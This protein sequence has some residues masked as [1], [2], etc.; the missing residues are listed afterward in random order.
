MDE[1]VWDLRIR[2]LPLQ[3][4]WKESLHQALRFSG[5][6]AKYAILPGIIPRLRS[7]A[8]VMAQFLFM[9]TRMFGAVGLI[10][11][12]HPCLNPAN[13]GRYRFNDIIGLAYFGLLQDIKNP[14]KLAMFIAVVGTF[15]MTVVLLF[16]T[17]A[18]ML[19]RVSIVGA[20]YYGDAPEN[21]GYTVQNDFAYNFLAEVFG[22]TGAFTF[23]GGQSSQDT[24]ILFGPIL[25][26]MFTTYSQAIMI[27]AVLTIIYLI[28]H[29]AIEAARTGKPFGER[30]NSVWAPFRIALGIALL[31]PISNGYNGAQYIAFQMSNWGS[32]LATNVWNEGLSAFG[33]LVE[34]P[35]DPQSLINPDNSNNLPSKLIRAAQPPEFYAF[36]RSVFL[37]YT[38]RDAMNLNLFNSCM[39]RFTLDLS[40]DSEGLYTTYFLGTFKDGKV[41]NSDYCGAYKVPNPYRFAPQMIRLDPGDT[42]VGIGKFPQLVAQRY[43]MFYEIS[44]PVITTVTAKITAQVHQNQNGRIQNMQDEDVDRLHVRLIKIYNATLGYKDGLYFNTNENDTPYDLGADEEAVGGP[45]APADFIGAARDDGYALLQV[46]NSAKRYGWASAGSTIMTLAHVNDIISTPV[47]T[48][49][50]LVSVPRLISNPIASPYFRNESLTKEGFF[51]GIASILGIAQTDLELLKKTGKTIAMADTWFT[52]RVRDK[53]PEDLNGD[54]NQD[55]TIA[56]ETGIR[57]S[58]WNEVANNRTDTSPESTDIMNA[59]GMH[60]FLMSFVGIGQENMNPI[61]KVVS[62]GSDMFVLALGILAFALF[63]GSVATIAFSLGIPMIIGAYILCVVVP[64]MLFG[65]FFFAVFEWVVSIFEVI[66][67]MPLWALSLISIEG[68]SIGRTGMSGI[69]KLFEIMLRPTIIVIATVGAMIVFSAAAHIFHKLFSMFM[70]T[71]FDTTSDGVTGEFKNVLVIFGSVLMYVMTIYSIGNACFKL[72]PTFANSFARWMNGPA[73]FSRI[74]RTAFDE[75]TGLGEFKSFMGQIQSRTGTGDE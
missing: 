53:W 45:I 65:N 28:G 12:S 52:D 31:V 49:P 36:M 21:T 32:A 17:V 2:Q 60:S 43:R 8:H 40:T 24:N 73:G 57:M 15:I 7:L 5:R 22:D 64:L 14:H 10:Q 55:D 72:I 26:A 27:L 3:S 20:Q 68:D 33:A 70:Q 46:L 59:G 4:E 25:R 38:C 42:G 29:M 71:Y 74:F 69:A 66:L 6:A 30:F 50:A 23:W 54:G 19:F 48:P 41:M 1:R 67:G 18:M 47:N 58:T 63:G 51:E 62:I 13:I 34:D 9:F 11:R 37:N 56:G 61:S 39:G 16:I 75:I 35:Q 44:L